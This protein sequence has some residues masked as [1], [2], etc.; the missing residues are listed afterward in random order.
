[1]LMDQKVTQDC[2]PGLPSQIYFVVVAALCFFSQTAARVLNQFADTD[3][4]VHTKTHH[5]PLIVSR[6]Q[7][8]I[9]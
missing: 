1:M 4:K 6:P 9:Y 3:A 5:V 8:S 7:E 2:A